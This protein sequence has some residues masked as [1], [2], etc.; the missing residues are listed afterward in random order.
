M[1]D[2]TVDL[3]RLTGEV[4]SNDPNTANI[5]AINYVYTPD[6]VGNR[7]SRS[8]GITAVSGQ[9]FTYDANDRIT[10]TGYVYDANGSTTTDPNGT[11]VYDSL[12]RMTQA[13]V[14]GITTSYVYDGDGN[15]VSQ[16]V[17]NGTTTNY[18]IDS[19]NLTD[20]AQVI[21]ELQGGSVNR[22][23]TYGISR[24]AEDQFNGSTWNVSYYGYDGQGSVRLL[25]NS[26]G[27]ITDTYDYDAFGKL[28]N[29]THIGSATPNVY[30]FDGEQSDASSG[31]YNLRARWMNPGVGRFQTMDDY[32]G[33]QEDPLSLHK[34]VFASNNPENKSDP[35]GN[36]VADSEPG[37]LWPGSSGGSGTGGPDVTAALNST[38][39]QVDSTFHSWFVLDRVKSARELHNWIGAAL[40]GGRS[41]GGAS[42]WDIKEL[43]QV[44]F[45]P[46][47]GI[48][49]IN[50]L[51]CGIAPWKYTVTFKGKCYYAGQVNYALWGEANKLVCSFLLRAGPLGGGLN[52]SDYSLTS[53]LDYVHE[54]KNLAYGSGDPVYEEEAAEFTRYGYDR[55]SPSNALPCQPSG[56]TVPGN[57]FTWGWNPIKP[58]WWDR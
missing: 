34:Y 50:G 24:I 3:Y 14:N 29:Q 42:A 45:G 15:K 40:G 13:T 7:Q 57:P 35:S 43:E 10:N 26:T 49:D 27:T 9:S 30:Q 28:I 32:E 47:N 1:P 19:N 2:Q 38:L 56:Q 20:S 31:F 53:A 54:W 46:Q 12:G 58:T 52:P 37:V 18:L 39:S 21:D 36:D 22:T 25:M 41:G 51:V 11:Y 8:S 6:G 55:E 23:Y 5:G 17:S 4:I 33:D 44:G 16:T 48:N